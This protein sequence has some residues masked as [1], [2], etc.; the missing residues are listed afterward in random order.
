MFESLTMLGFQLSL[1]LGFGLKLEFELKLECLL[2]CW[3]YLEY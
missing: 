3:L 1:M 2:A